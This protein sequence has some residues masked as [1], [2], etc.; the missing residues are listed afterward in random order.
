MMQHSFS[1]LGT[2]N[3]LETKGQEDQFR[4]CHSCGFPAD[5]I[6]VHAAVDS[7]CQTPSHSTESDML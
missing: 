3:L 7:I 4:S 5:E 6:I 2:E 1:F